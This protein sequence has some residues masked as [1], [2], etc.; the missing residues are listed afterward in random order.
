MR[1]GLLA[2]SSSGGNLSCWTA[3]SASSSWFGRG[4]SVASA[5]VFS[6]RIAMVADRSWAGQL[7]SRARAGFGCKIKHAA[8]LGG[9]QRGQWMV[10][11]WH[12]SNRLGNYR[13]SHATQLHSSLAL[14]WNQNR[15]VPLFGVAWFAWRGDSCNTNTISSAYLATSSVP[16]IMSG[17]RPE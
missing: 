14:A 4:S 16:C 5:G 6:L 2:A 13:F 3:S 11:R 7:H 1:K 17:A 9:A 12:A 8:R 15:W 10:L